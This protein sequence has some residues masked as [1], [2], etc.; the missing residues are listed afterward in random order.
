[1]RK[2]IEF[3]IVVAILYP[4]ALFLYGK[5]VFKNIRENSKKL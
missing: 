4:I 1:M 5:D 2:K 3:W